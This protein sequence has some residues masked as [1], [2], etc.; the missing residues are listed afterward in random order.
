MYPGTRRGVPQQ[1]ATV[2][3]RHKYG[4]L[5]TTY[6]NILPIEPDGTTIQ[7]GLPGC[8]FKVKGT[9]T[10]ILLRGGEGVAVIMGRDGTETETRFNAIDA[11]FV[12]W[13]VPEAAA[14][15]PAK[16]VSAGMPTK[17]SGSGL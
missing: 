8:L 13:Y 10:G 15:S 2:A 4:T 16:I 6:H 1:D 12:F 11:E 17:R 9:E 3:N 14:G 7:P 5:S